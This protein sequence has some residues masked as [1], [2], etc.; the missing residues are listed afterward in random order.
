MLGQLSLLTGL[1]LWFAVLAFVM[2]QLCLL[3][4]APG[5]RALVYSPSYSGDNSSLGSF[6]E[7]RILHV[8]LENH[9]G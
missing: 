8:F 9:G 7:H 6:I 5:A 2:N 1:V 3:L 4:A